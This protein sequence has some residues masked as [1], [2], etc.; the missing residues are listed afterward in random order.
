[1]KN[2]AE[3]LPV[4]EPKRDRRKEEKT[5]FILSCDGQ[6]A[7]RKRPDRGLLA[8]LWEFPNVPQKLNTQAIVNQVEQYGLKTKDIKLQVERKHIFT[9]IEWDMCGAY[10]EVDACEGGFVWMTAEQLQTQA[11]LPT[12]FR[13]F[14]EELKNDET[15]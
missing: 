3:Q 12:A 15:H 14:W 5:V 10:V 6:Y 7:L 1:L 11:A 8:G 2:T 9:H 4:K 13:L